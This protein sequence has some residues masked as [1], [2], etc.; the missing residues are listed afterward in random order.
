MIDKITLYECGLKGQLGFSYGLV[1][2]VN[3][4]FVCLEAHGIEGWG[5]AIALFGEE[6]F[7]EWLEA[8]EV[9]K[10]LIGKDPCYLEA[11]LPPVS[12]EKTGN[13]L[14]EGLDIALHDLIGRRY[15][16]PVHTLL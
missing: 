7:I 4:F 5:E 2:Q 13:A 10:S 11:L 6:V 16:L 1:E 3:Y 9:C 15:A 8:I 12:E 14:R